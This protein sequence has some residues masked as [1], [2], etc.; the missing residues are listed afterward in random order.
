MIGHCFY[1]T[2]DYFFVFSS[3]FLSWTFFCLDLAL[4]CCGSTALTLDE[5]T[6]G[7]DR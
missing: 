3:F 2:S 6:E 4:S 7:P 5:R 1:K